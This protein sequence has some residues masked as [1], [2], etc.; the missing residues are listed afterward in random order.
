MSISGPCAWLSSLPPPSTSHL[1]A[2]TTHWPTGSWNTEQISPKT[3]VFPSRSPR[4]WEIE[5][6]PGKKSPVDMQPAV[7]KAENAFPP[8]TAA[9]ASSGPSSSAQYPGVELRVN[10]SEHRN[11]PA[12]TD[13]SLSR[14]RLDKLNHSEPVLAAPR[15]AVSPKTP[16]PENRKTEAEQTRENEKDTGEVIASSDEGTASPGKRPLE[17]KNDK[18]KM[19]RFRL[20]HN[21][22]RFLMSEFT[23]Q[24]HPDAAHRERL[25]REIPGLTP[26]QVQ[27]WFQN[28]R[29]KLKR[30][31][32]ND[33]ER[34][35]KSRALPDDFDT[36]QVL[37]T[38]FD[39]KAPDAPML[40]TDG[41]QRLNDDDYVISPLSSASTNNGFP[42]AGPDR[43]L[44]GYAAPVGRGPAPLSTMQRNRNAFPFPRSSSFSEPSYNT[45]LHFPGRFSRP[46]EPLAHP[47][48]P[49]GRRPMDYAM[50]RP[51]GMVVGYDQHRQMD[52]SVSPTEPH[53]PYSM[54][55]HNQP[56]H[57]YQS[58]LTMPAP[59]GYGMEMSSHMQQP[60]RQMPALQSLPVS[61]PAE[62]RPYTY[63]QH[64]QPP[65]QHPY[66][67]NT[68]LP[69]TQANASSMSLPAS[70]PSDASA[71]SH[72][73]ASS[74]ADD[75]TPV[76][77]AKFGSQTFE[78]ANYL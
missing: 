61:E 35:L 25:S 32:S 75:R 21:Q 8:A 5:D 34:M 42:T 20:T 41:L 45:S 49:Y 50:S 48:L 3:R 57:S 1:S 44:E 39:G 27:V 66:S 54:D 43:N 29:A 46:G 73:A 63:D 37:R 64:H 18:K 76:M 67:M 58:P 77:G 65:P 36:T 53:M 68:A 52:G 38:P 40:L 56:V 10:P 51:N 33:R 69:Y 19:K 60:G 70:F 2:I 72:G 59:K 17:S 23:R 16:Q 4:A 6:Q 12:A 9:P 24:A 55:G 28:R 47:G 11:A 30:L 62:Y 7:L 74:A 71:V 14:M 78:Y 13:T 31:T 15:P 26:R 22:T